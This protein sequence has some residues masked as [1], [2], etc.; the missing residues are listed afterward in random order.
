M[1]PSEGA[2]VGVGSGPGAGTITPASMQD[3]PPPAMS[4]PP[5]SGQPV[6]LSP[7]K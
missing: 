3:N 1:A 5:A 4:T 2:G 7:P 6:P